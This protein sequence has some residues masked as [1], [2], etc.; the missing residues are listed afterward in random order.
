LASIERESP[1]VRPRR[2]FYVNFNPTAG[3]AR[4][5]F[6][7]E[8]TAQL[9]AAGSHVMY[10]AADT[11]DIAARAMREAA[12]SGDYDAIIACGGDGTIR[13]AVCAAAGTECPVGTVMLGTGNVLAWEL[14]LPRDIDGLVQLLR[15]GA[16]RSIETGLVNGEPF[17]L[18][19]S[20]GFDGRAIAALDG[21]LKPMLGRAAFVPA[22][23]Q[24]VTAPVDQLDVLIDG[25]PHRAAWVVATRARHYGGSFTLTERAGLHRTGLQVVVVKATSRFA[26]VRRLLD[27]PLGALDEAALDPASGVTIRE[28][29]A[30]T[31]S[32]ATPVPAQVDGDIF[33]TTPLA[34]TT[35][36]PPVRII[37]P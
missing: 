18:M 1:P 26:L 10:G 30:V 35:G 37:C 12:R 13:K 33:G 14:G 11:P 16:E 4:R 23:L 2:R 29:S 17:L 19:A 28:A 27:V 36:G 8:L 7:S 32:A 6:V 15:E 31:I 9:T 21:R 24:A 5:R 25:T 20:A 22:T 3:A 34:I